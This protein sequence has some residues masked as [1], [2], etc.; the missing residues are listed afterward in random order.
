MKKI[1]KRIK[2][3]FVLFV[4]FLIDRDKLEKLGN[5]GYTY[6]IKEDHNVWK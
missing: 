2:I 1:I 6:H 4:D 5:K 3:I